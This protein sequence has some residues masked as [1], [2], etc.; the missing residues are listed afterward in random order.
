MNHE[1]LCC[2]SHKVRSSAI[3][4]HD[5]SVVSPLP[6]L[7]FGGDIAAGRD[8]DQETITVDKWIV[9]QAP[10]RIAELVKVRNNSHCI[11]FFAIQP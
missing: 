8:R 4:I 5:T 2:V 7:F 3:F 6:L 9:F 11:L 1:I 10:L